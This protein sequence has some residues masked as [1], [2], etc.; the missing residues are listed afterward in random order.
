MLRRI[1]EAFSPPITHEEAWLCGPHFAPRRG[2]R[3][4]LLP[5]D[6]TLRTRYAQAAL[7]QVPHLLGLI[8]RNPYRATYGC[9]DRQ[10]W[11]YRTS[12]FP[13]EMYQEGALTLALLYRW[14]LPGN[15]WF[16][17]PRLREWAVAAIRF[18]ARSSH[19]DGS[20]DDYYPFER[21]LGAAVFSLQ[22][23]VQAYRVLG[24]QD[25]SLL[26]WFERRAAWIVRHDE[27]GRLSNHHAL[28]ALGLLRVAQVTGDSRWREAA[29]RRI[30]CLLAWQS[31]EGWFEE[32][33]GA[34]PG[35]QSVTIDCLAKYRRETGADWFDEA[36]HRAVEFSRACLHP[37]GSYAGPYGSRG[38]HHFYPH[39]C[40]LLAA[41]NASAADLADGFLQAVGEG[42]QAWFDDDRLFIHRLANLIEAHLDWSPTRAPAQA[43]QP[44]WQS[45]PQAGLAVRHTHD[46]HTVISAARGG[47]FQH[48]A[49]GKLAASDT[50]LVVEL[51]DRRVA[52]SQ[53]HDRNSSDSNPIAATA[54]AHSADGSF[55]IVRPLHYAPS[56]QMTPWKLVLLRGFMLT[57]GRFGR[58]FVRKLLQR[59]LIT[60]RQVAPI[61]LMRRFE[62]RRGLLRV[63]DTIQLH[64][65]RARV[66][67]MSFGTDHESTY[68]AATGVYQDAALL[69]WHDL[70]SYVERLN[71]E[72]VVTVVREFPA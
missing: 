26:D 40:E 25:A 11:H 45:F 67:R 29:D 43:S 23:T 24:L 65:P 57:V 35:Y 37:D 16:G 19:P 18:A 5:R 59:R 60:R 14:D 44:T 54:A 33:G 52:V 9:L 34:D 32:Y 28:A 22:A 68:V 7:T 27:S 62:F 55:E 1:P 58:S 10:Y 48:F 12:D 50:G 31:P 47:V 41:E 30:S 3:T 66:R 42:R 6:A 56:E 46:A 20:C 39:G 61:Q 69:P 53:L 71:A 13:S 63:I 21:A 49:A 70:S 15:R 72:R 8:D 38:T 17:E 36:L 2:R 64:A 4:R 51:E